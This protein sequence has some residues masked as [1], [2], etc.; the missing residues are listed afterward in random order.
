MPGG[1][2][3]QILRRIGACAT[4]VL[5]AIAVSFVMPATASAQGHLHGGAAG[6]RSAAQTNEERHD[7]GASG[8]S[9]DDGLNMSERSQD[10]AVLPDTRDSGHDKCK[11]PK[12]N[13]P[14]L[15]WCTERASGWMGSTTLRVRTIP[16]EPKGIC[17]ASSVHSC[18]PVISPKAIR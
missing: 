7:G 18:R 11:R 4:A 6:H 10:A 17:D 3:S 13:R 8:S 14:L 2:A 16:P 9:T 15:P 1:C 12:G 5:V